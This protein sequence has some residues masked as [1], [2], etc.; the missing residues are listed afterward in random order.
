MMCCSL[1]CRQSALM[2]NAS[3]CALFPVRLA[4]NHTHGKH[5]IS[6][7]HSRC[8]ILMNSCRIC[9][10]D[11]RPES[12]GSVSDIDVDTVAELN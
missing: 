4:S 7:Y 2:H 10:H 3:N 11:A 6:S 12:C 9:P 8:L 5:P 1:K